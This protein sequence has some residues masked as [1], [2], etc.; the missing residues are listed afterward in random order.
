[1]VGKGVKKA[2]EDKNAPKTGLCLECEHG[3]I[4]SDGVKGNPLIVECSIDKSRYPQSWSCT[5]NNFIRRVG[6]L[7]I[8][9]MIYLNRKY[10]PL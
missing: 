9:S 4:M 5:I 10:P 6:E 2:K 3:Y 1:M 7:V 8:H